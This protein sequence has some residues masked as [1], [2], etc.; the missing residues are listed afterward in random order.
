MTN[1][2]TKANGDSPIEEKGKGAKQVP[3]QKGKYPPGNFDSRRTLEFSHDDKNSYRMKLLYINEKP[4]VGFSKFFLS[5]KGQWLPGN[6]HF[7]MGYDVWTDMMSHI[8][9]FS[10]L[11]AKGK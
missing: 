6:K 2:P 11:I 7:Y 8:E 4:Y 9:K 3:G 1:V 5:N 10:K